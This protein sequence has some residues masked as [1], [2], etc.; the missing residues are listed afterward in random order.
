VS[1]KQ[2]IYSKL[3]W[4]F[5]N[6]LVTIY[7]LRF[8]NTHS[9]KYQKLKKEYENFFYES[10]FTIIEEDQNKRFLEL[11]EY[12]KKNNRNYHR[13]LKYIE[14]N[15]INDIYKIPIISKIEFANLPSSI[16][17]EKKIV[18]YTGGSTGVSTK[19][20][21]FEN[22]YIERQANLDF[23]RGMYGYNFKDSIAWFSGKEIITPSDVKKNKFWVKDYLNNITYYST[24]HLSEKY[25]LSMIGELNKSNIEY[26]AGFPSAIY[27]IA[28]IWKQRNI[29]IEINL[30]AI[31]PTSEP[32]D[33]NK[34]EFLK[35]FFGCVVPDQYASS[36][37]AHFIFECPHGSLHYDM[38]SGIFE[39]EDNKLL[40]TSFTTR[41]M[42]LIRF[43]IGD[44]IELDDSGKICKCGSKMP[45]V[46]KIIGRTE[47]YLYSPERGK[48][49]VSNIS[50]VIK[51]LKGVRKL[52]IIQNDNDFSIL[53]KYISDTKLEKELRYE[54]RYRLGEGIK[55]S[56]KK[57]DE[58]E[59]SK[60]GKF[61][62]IIHE[63]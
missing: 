36:E 24:F 60:N 63:S 46:N 13:T 58:I 61:K 31:F 2:S 35:D 9:A 16:S 52:Q 34:K 23:F 41:C 50:N 32:L 22:D 54:L 5:K 33:N 10:D 39:I 12:A 40:V 7:N 18:G 1:L 49:T 37:G 59:A 26:M 57:V 47:D 14:I 53:V 56:Y 48:V 30:K 28:F 19:F 42:P 44:I 17:D 3:P 6:I 55:I 20:Y 29:P 51:Y 43:D 8:L 45:I 21:L 62:M 27:D 11:I 38:H 15:S 4:T 25:I